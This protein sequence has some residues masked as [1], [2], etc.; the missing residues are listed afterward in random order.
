MRQRADRNRS[1]CR[2]LR[3]LGARGREDSDVS[4]QETD[5]WTVGTPWIKGGD[6]AVMTTQGKTP[7]QDSLD[8]T[9]ESAALLLWA[10][11]AGRPAPIVCHLLQRASGT[12]SV[13]LHELH[14]IPE[15]E[16][17]DLVLRAAAPIRSSP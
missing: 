8:S 4:D 15:A 16:Q 12:I 11:R 7:V 17:V 1:I 2:R 5:S 14:R 3:G 10:L 6:D 9:A 13:A